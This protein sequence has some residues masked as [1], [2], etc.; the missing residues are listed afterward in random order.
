[1]NCKIIRAGLYLSQTCAQGRAQ[2]E[3]ETSGSKNGGG[4]GEYKTQECFGYFCFENFIRKQFFLLLCCCVGKL[5]LNFFIFETSESFEFP[6]IV[7]F[8]PSLNTEKEE[9]NG[10]K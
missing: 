2:D 6:L 1:M 8:P 3:T 9:E 7:S 10:E 5:L 4:S